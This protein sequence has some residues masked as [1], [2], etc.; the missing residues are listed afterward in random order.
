[1]L[2]IATLIA[3]KSI[4]NFLTE[5][6]IQ[7]NTIVINQTEVCSIRSQTQI[8]KCITFHKKFHELLN[9]TDNKLF[10]YHK[11]SHISKNANKLK[12]KTFV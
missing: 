9:T 2:K 7:I 4:W 11:I 1:M 5:K 10:A 12:I 6:H 8:L 3:I